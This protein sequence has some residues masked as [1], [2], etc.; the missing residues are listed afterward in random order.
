MIPLLRIAL[1]ARKPGPRRAQS[2]HHAALVGKILPVFGNSFPFSFHGTFLR[3]HG[4]LAGL[5]QF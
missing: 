3:H 1:G 2:R 5:R 4:L